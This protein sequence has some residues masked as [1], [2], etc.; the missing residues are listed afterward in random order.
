M[1]S[2]TN[3]ISI[4]VF[5]ANK[6]RNIIAIIAIILTTV[7]FTS[8]FT[9]VQEIRGAIRQQNIR[10]IGTDG[11]VALK[12]IDDYIYNTIKGDKR[13][14]QISY[15]V[16]VADAVV[17]S[18]LSS[19]AIEMWYMDPEGLELYNCKP[20]VGNYPQ[21]TN[22]IMMDTGT[23]KKLNVPIELGTV[24]ELKYL[25]KGNEVSKQFILSGFYDPDPLLNVGRI[26]VSKS[27]YEENRNQLLNTYYEDG[28]I[29]GTVHSYIFFNNALFLEDKLTD[30]L[31]DY[32]FC[33][34]DNGTEDDDR[35]V[36]GSVSPAYTT[37]G[38]SNPT[39]IIGILILCV[40]IFLTGFLLIYNIFQISIMQDIHFY[41][42]L[43]VIG[44]S[45]KQ[46][47]SVVKKQAGI[48]GII[49]IP[50]GLLLGG[51]FGNILMPVIF[52][53]TEFLPQENIKI[54]FS[55]M[56]IFISIFFSVITIAVS[57]YRPAVI[58]AKVTPIEALRYEKN[59]EC[60]KKVK[61]SY[62]RNRVYNLALANMS[63]DRK[64]TII[65]IISMSLGL[66][67]L[68]LVVTFTNSLNMDKY[69]SAQL[70]NDFLVSSENYFSGFYQKD[71]NTIDENVIDLLESQDGFEDGG[72]IY[73]QKQTNDE[74]ELIRGFSINN[75][76]KSEYGICKDGNSPANIYG[77]D[78]FWLDQLKVVE[79]KID[80]DKLKSGNY[81]LQGNG[82][83]EETQIGDTVTLNYYDNNKGIYQ[84]KEY[85][86]MAKVQSDY[87]NTARFTYG[88]VFYMPFEEYYSVTTDDSIM[89]YSFNCKDGYESQFLSLLEDCTN[90]GIELGWES[91]EQLADEFKST[92]LGIMF[93]GGSLSIIIGILGLANFFNS[94]YTSILVR[95]K[96]FAVLQSIGMSK[97][98][99]K[100]ML[101]FEG[102]LYI[103]GA[104]ALALI[105]GAVLS[106]V[107][108]R[109][110]MDMADWFSYRFTLWPIIFCIP[111][112]LILAITLPLVIYRNQSKVSIVDQLRYE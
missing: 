90:K 1:K 84:T 28:S 5:K 94:L 16:V 23:L 54:E 45:K 93:V 105:L 58:A 75:M 78:D 31:N 7:L 88:Y 53:L 64:R 12:N 29:A 66:V 81:I 110:M 14:K 41:G 32:G 100:T 47:K 86:I 33:W 42:Q 25:V 103:A 85:V 70:S 63:R 80:Q 97:K 71:S 11:H 35:Y 101:V 98:Q 24:I 92:E 57:I 50:V 60:K 36:N 91:R 2:I 39:I 107:I 87:S 46:I 21:D 20:Q 3:K 9:V 77:V 27:Y 4:K 40:F 30:L 96:E 82:N 44:A 17:N 106:F 89:S 79:G 109:P 19:S 34:A 108:I 76:D 18:E 8:L 52:K 56:I 83:G 102:V 61:K 65:S 55:V 59:T 13:I 67:I 38:A 68:V 111:F 51:I 37:N 48:L 74:N 43:K 69:V 6:K 104:L 62:T 15:G 73:Y 10:M 72:R 26:F 49:G 99:L 95:K 22:E 112:L